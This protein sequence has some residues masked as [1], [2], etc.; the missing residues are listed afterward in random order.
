MLMKLRP[1]SIFFLETS[2]ATSL[3][4]KQCCALEST[5]SKVIW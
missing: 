3:E 2:G 5:A 4:A 1:D